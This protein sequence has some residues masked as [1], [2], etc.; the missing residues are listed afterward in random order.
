MT[1]KDKLEDPETFD[2]RVANVC[3]VYLQ[4]A[5]LH[6]QGIHVISTDEKTGMQAL[7][8]E[9]P[10]KPVRPGQTERIEFEYIRHGALCL[11]ANLEVATGKI[12]SPTIGPT[13]TNDDFVRHID[14][15]VRTDPHGTWVFVVDN[16]DIHKSESLT[17]Y[18]ADA[19]GDSQD[20]GRKAGSGPG[21]GHLKN[22]A[23]RT[24]Y[25]EDPSHRIRFVFTPRHCSWLNQIEL[26]FSV[27]ARRFLRR[28]SFTSLDELKQRLQEFITYFNAVLAHPY[29][30]TFTGRP[31][32][33]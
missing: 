6:K 11:I 27:L 18:V 3:D 19:I 28:S 13:R 25:L 17:N 4:A 26:W 30:W 14:R 12:L 9:F 21:H 16:L 1:S 32:A 2:K 8:R 24:A 31:L 20:L 7:E 33:A 29:R 5:D 15:L 23:S 10:T 22:R